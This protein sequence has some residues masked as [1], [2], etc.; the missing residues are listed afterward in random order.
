MEELVF[1][2]WLVGV[3]FWIVITPILVIK[4]LRREK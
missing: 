2:L 1:H 4:S 3:G